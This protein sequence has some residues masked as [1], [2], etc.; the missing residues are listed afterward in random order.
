[1][2]FSEEDSNNDPSPSPLRWTLPPES[3]RGTVWDWFCEHF[4]FYFLK[5][6]DLYILGKKSPKSNIFPQR[7]SSE[8][9]H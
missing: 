4:Y 5:L 8:Q 7:H 9:T 1:V 6:A 3:S 2:F